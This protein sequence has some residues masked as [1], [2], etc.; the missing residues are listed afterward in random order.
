MLKVRPLT[1]EAAQKLLADRFEDCKQQRMQYEPQWRTNEVILYNALAEETYDY[2]GP[3]TSEVLQ[4]V[5]QDND[6]EE[7]GVNYI[8]KHHRFLNA[9]MSAN[10]PSVQVRPTSSDPA[11]KRRADTADRL[12]RHAIRAYNMQEKIDLNNGSAL[13]YGSAFL[14]TSFD[15]NKGEIVSYDETSGNLEMSG[16]FSL[17]NL[18]IWDVWI[19]PH[20]RSW[21]EVEY[22]FER[23]W[24]TLDECVQRWPD[25]E[26]M[27]TKYLENLREDMKNEGNTSRVNLRELRVP[28]IQYWEKGLPVNGMQGRFVHMLPDARLVDS[29]AKNPYRFYEI[30]EDKE[31][32][33]RQVKLEAM[34][35]E[36]DRGPEVAGLPFHIL[37]DI[38]VT[39]HVYG[40]SFI[41]YA[42]PAQ[43]TINRLDTMTLENVAAHG[44]CRIVL[45]EGADIAEDSI[46]DSPWEIIRVEGGRD[47][48]F[49]ETPRLMPE[50]NQLRD[51][52]RGGIEDMAGVNDSM[53]GKQEREQSGFSMQYATNQGNMIRRRI[54]NKYVLLVEGVYKSYLA[55]IQRHWK[56]DRT[57]KVL[58]R[59][60]SYQLFDVKG[61]DILGG[62]DMVVEYG[63]SL[64]L[65]PTSR[66]EEIM[67]LMPLFE[68]AGVDSRSLMSMLKL[69]ELEGMH[70]LTELGQARQQEIFEK[71]I[72][73]E[74]NI[75]IP[76]REMADHKNMLIHCN[77]FVMTAEFRDLDPKIQKMIELHITDRVALSQGKAPEGAAPAQPSQAIQPPVEQ[78]GLA[79]PQMAPGIPMPGAPAIPQI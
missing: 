38:D 70:D 12:C 13:L 54:F 52:H 51:K 26:E 64:S 22:V 17:R 1:D 43:D 71:I 58:G 78:G 5:F 75:Y 67:A 37:T 40:K 41:E 77:E 34:G 62:Y 44:Y 47:P 20:A 61:S 76:P 31:E 72:A 55:L 30:N 8:F 6:S 45:P 74:G 50:V 68:K 36:V 28:I 32:V 79:T 9:Q 4:R 16:D 18:T 56:D 29:V 11:D 65:D 10:P 33:A 21:G 35:L 48:H 14:K 2:K 25:K 57:I 19:D 7:S 3:V 39:D 66:R 63:S 53:Y 59:E 42:A 15:E 46:T 60:K 23:K 24:Y 49:F 27:L 73:G 69:N